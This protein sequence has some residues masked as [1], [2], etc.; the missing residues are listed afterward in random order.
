[1]QGE[2]LRIVEK[3]QSRLVLNKRS[4]SLDMASN[5]NR[6]STDSPVEVE[7]PAQALQVLVGLSHIFFS[8]IESEF[9]FPLGYVCRS[10]NLQKKKMATKCFSTSSFTKI[11]WKEF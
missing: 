2:I 6:S 4:C 8:A 1:M 5:D 9:R 7:E 3:N 10:L 11:I